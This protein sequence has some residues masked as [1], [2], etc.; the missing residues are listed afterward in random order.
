MPG[1]RFREKRRSDRIAIALPIQV[2]GIDSTGQS[3]QEYT[4]T[5]EVG[6]YGAKFESKRVL[7]ANQNVQIVNLRQGT[8]GTFRVVGQV[9]NSD[10]GGFFWGAECVGLSPTFWGFYFPPLKKGQ[11][12]AARIVL[13]CEECRTQAM[14]YLSD[15]ETEVFNLTGRVTVFCNTCQRWTQCIEP[16]RESGA[17]TPSPISTAN[18]SEMRTCRRLP[19][20]MRACLQTREGEQEKVRTV[21]ISAGGLAVLS[22]RN[23]PPGAL[24]KVAFPFLEGSGNIFVLGQV[25]RISSTEEPGLMYYG[26]EYLR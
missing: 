10:P 3:F 18:T 15:L 17:E 2:S 9:P 5:S 21:N 8:D 1:S 25:A 19:L 16:P 23:Y 4:K 26:I 6:L 22:K 14:N 12:E 11:G 7:Q 20:K 13:L 24:L